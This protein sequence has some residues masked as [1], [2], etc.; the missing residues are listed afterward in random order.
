MP[1]FDVVQWSPQERVQEPTAEHASVS[2]VMPVGRATT[3]AEGVASTVVESD[4]DCEA[5]PPG[6]EVPEFVFRDRS[7]QRAFQRLADI[8]EVVEKPFFKVFSQDQFLDV[9][10][11]RVKEQLVEVP[12]FV[13]QDSVQQ[14][15]FKQFADFPDSVFSSSLSNFPVDK[16]GSQTSEK[17]V[18]VVKAV[19]LGESPSE[20]LSGVGF[21]SKISSPCF[22][23]TNDRTA[24]ECAHDCITRQSP[25]MECRVHR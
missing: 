21:L 7:K 5:R 17:C 6:V 23:A 8:S 24:D 12:F 11:T 25:A 4:D 13:C 9:P 20:V 14:R 22:C 3:A 1:V 16:F 15:T 10:V 19:Y 18:K 2:V